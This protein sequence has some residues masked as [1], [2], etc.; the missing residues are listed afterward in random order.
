MPASSPDVMT[1]F[2]SFDIQARQAAARLRTGAP[3]TIPAFEDT[4][5]RARRRSVT[6][7][8]ATAVA[9]VVLAAGI[10]VP[11]WQHL[12]SDTA[13]T[14]PSATEPIIGIWNLPPPATI[15]GVTVS[16]TPHTTPKPTSRPSVRGVTGPWTAHVSHNRLAL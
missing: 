16:P 2:D 8:S 11:A 4:L 6:R 3:D 12:A 7:T 15:V 9:A 10:A 5:R 1:D 14:A 13:P